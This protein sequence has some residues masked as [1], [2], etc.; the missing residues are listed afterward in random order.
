MNRIYKVIWNR[1]RHCYVVVSEIAKNHGKEH[2]TNLCVSKRL[3]ALTLAIGLSLSSYAFVM[4]ADSVNLGNNA[5]AA[6]D[7][8]GNLTIGNEKT[9]ADGANKNGKNNTTIGTDSDTLRNVTEG[10]TKKNGQ[11]MDTDAN[12]QL[13]EGEGKAHDLDTSTEAGGSTAMGYNTHNEGDNSTAIGNNAK[14]TNK[15]V[16]YYVDAD[17]KKTASADNAAWYK[18]ASGNPTKVPQVFRDAGGNKTTT[19]QYVHTYTEKDPTTGENVTK[20]E[21]TSDATKADKDSGGNPVYNYE[22]ADNTDKLY[23][24]TL[25]QA[26]SNSIAAG[27]NVTAKG[28]NAV[29]VG[30]NSSADNSAVAIGDT[31]KAKENAVAMGKDTK[32]MAEGSIAL[33]KDSEADRDGGVAGWDPKTGTASTKSDVAWKSGE[34]ALSIGNGGASR[35]ITNVAAGSEDSDAVNLAQLKNAMTHY[36]SV[37]T[38]SDTDAAG[39]NNYLNDGA[40]GDNALAAGVGA[41]ASSDDATA[42]GTDANAT[43]SQATA[44]GRSASASSYQDTAIGYNAGAHG[45]YATAVGSSASATSFQSTAIGYNAGAHGSYAIAMGNGAS[46]TN[47]YAMAIGASANASYENSTAVGASAKA[48]ATY[49]TALGNGASA[50]SY[51]STAVGNGASASSYE[52]TAIGSGAGADGSYAIAMGNGASATNSYAVAIGAGANAPSYQATALGNG[53]SATSS[54]A[55]A[56][57]TGAGAHG[58]SATALGNGASANSSYATALGSGATAQLS[59]DTAIGSSAKASGGDATALGYNAQATAPNATAL[60]SGASAY[61]HAIAIGAASASSSYA[62]AAGDGANAQEYQAIALGYNAKSNVTGGV[63][64]GS[65]STANVESGK[66]GLDPHTGAASTN[67]G[68]TWVSTLGAVSVGTVDSD[69]NA[70]GT[71]QINGLAA[72]TNDTDAVN[73]AQLKALETRINMH[74]YSVNSTLSGD[75][76]NYD[77]TGAS[78]TNALAA[79]PMA[80]ASGEDAVAIGYGAQAEGKGA[81]VIGQYGKATGRY[82]LAFG[83]QQTD[84]TAEQADNVASGD[85]ALSFG[86]RTTAS[87]TNSTAF[88]WQTTANAKRA[89]AFGERTTASGANA[90]VFGQLATASGQNSVAFGNEAVANNYGSTAFGNRTEALGE[91]STAFGNSTVAAGMNTAAFGTDNVA[92]AVLDDNG[93][94]TNIIY[95]TNNNGR[96]VKDTNGNPIELSREKMDARGN[97]AYL[98]GSGH[99]KSVTYTVPG[100]ETHSYVLLQGT[101][102]NTYIRDYRGHIRSATIGTDG[103]VTVGDTASADVTLK[104]ATAGANG[105]HILSNANATVW[106]ENSIASGEASTA[107]GVGSI[108]AAQNSLAA[109]GGTVGESATNAAAIGSGAKATLEDSVALGSGAVADR[110]SGAKGYD[111]LTKGDTTNT[112][113]AWVSN[114]NAIAVGNG[115]TLTRQ[116]TGVAAGS[117]DTDAVNVAQ[118][119]AAGFKVTTQNDGSISSSI[120][121][122]DTLDFEGKDNAI[123]ST[124]KDSK[125]ITVAVSKTPTFDSAT[126]Y[127]P[128]PSEGQNNEKVTISNGHI[129]TYNKNQQER[130]V[131]GTDNQGSGT[132]HLINNDLSQVHVYTQNSKDDGNDGITRMYYIS[133]SGNGGE[134][135]GVHTIAV[136]D[137]GI[138]YAGDNVKPNTSDKVVVKH[139]LNSTMDVTGGAD[140]NNL[141]EGNIGVVATPAVEDDQGNITQKAKLELKLNKDLT[142]LNTVTAGTAQIGSA[143]AD[144][145]KLTENGAVT[146]KTA[147][148][149]SYVTGLDNKDWSTTNPSYVSGRAATEDQLAAVSGTI[150]KGLSFT[151]NTQDATNT[152][153]NYTGYKVVNRK[154]GDTIAIKAGDADASRHYATTNLTTEIA[155]N[156]DITIKMD[157]SPTFTE[158]TASSFNLSP[159]DTTTKDKAGNTASAQLNAHY[160]DGSLNPDKNVT[161]ADGSTGMVRLHYH[162]GEGTIHDLA[163]MDDG[164][165]YAGDIK[166][167][168]S[169]DTTGFGRKMNEKTTI[170]GGVT[171]KDNLSD[172][173]IGVVSDGTSTL[174]VKLA[175]DLKNLN[176]V[177]TGKTIQNDSGITITNDIHNPNKTVAVK[178]DEVTFGGNQVTNM[179]SGADG[180]AD[181]K[182]DGTP[183]YNT[184][185]NGANIGDVK[186]IAGSTT[187]AAK[188]TGD[189]NITV[190]YNDSTA[191]GKNTVKLND[192]IT[193][194]S[195]ADK[196]VTIDGT[197]G[198]ITA[199]GK[200]SLDGSTG[201]GSIGGVTIGNQTGVTTT[202]MD[203][204]KAKTEDGTFVTGLSNKT[205][206][207]DSNGIVSGRAATED[208]LKTVSDTVNAGWELDVNGTKQKAVTPTSSKVNFVQGQNIS[209]SG[210]GDD[211]IVA[212]AD[213]VRFTTIHVTGDKDDSGSYIGG[214]TI[215]KQSGGNS[216]NPGPGYY[217]TGLENKSWNASQIQSGRAAT[218]DQLKQVAE[219]I[220]H[221]TVDGDKYVTGGTATY[222]DDGKGSAKL[223]GTNGLE[224]T[225]AN[226]H[227]YYVTKGEVSDDG[228]TLKMTKND[229]T[230]FD[231]N[232]GKIMQ[233][234][235]RL[236]QNPA[237]EDGKYTVDSDGNLKLTVQD[238]NGTEATRQTITLSGLASK[239][240]VDK[241]LTFAANSG[242]PYKA[243]LG[244]TVTVKGSAVKAGHDYSDENLTTEVDGNGNITIKMDKDLTADTMTV[245]GK[246]G[247]DGQIGITGKDGA[248]GTVTTIIKTIGK[249]GTNG[250]DGTPGVN[251]TDGITRIVYQDGKDG[252]A[253]MTTHTVATLD[254]GLKFGANAPVAGKT[255]N[256]VGNKMNSTINI[257]GAGTKELQDYSGKNLLTSVEQD[258]AGNTTIHVLMDRNISADGVTVG[259]AGKDG[260][261]GADSEVG[262][263][264]TIGINGKNGV[265][266]TDGKQGITTTIIR[267]EKGQAGKDGEIGQQG[268]PGVDGKDITRIVYQN[269]QDKVDGKDGSHTVA[270]LD[271]GLKFSGD[272]NKV[273]T[274]KLNEQLQFVGGADKNKLTE[275]NIGINELEDGKLT[276][277]L[278]N[279]P[280]LGENGNLTAGSAQIG[281]FAGDTLDMTKDGTNPSGNKAKAGSYA[282]G[283]SNKDWNVADP[284]YVS[285]R[286]ATEDQLAKVSEA[287]GNATTAA[288]KR[289]VVTVNDKSNPAEATPSATAGAYGDYDSTGGNLMIAAKK[290]SD[291]VLTY[292]IKLNDQLAIGQKGEPGVAGKDGKDGKVT[293]E[294]KGG[295]TVVIGHDGE[296][297]KDGKD[298]IFVTGKDG[299]DGV[300]ITGPDGAAGTDGKVGIAGTDGKDAVS[301]SGKDGVGHIGLIGPKGADGK[302]ADIDIS[303]VLGKATLDRSQN[304][305]QSD[306]KDGVKDQASRIQYQTIVKEADGTSRT[307]THEV[308]TM[309]D[310]LKI[311][312]NAA[313]KE[314]AANPVSNKLNSTINIKGSD[315]KAD[316]TYT[317]DNL[318]TTVE[319]DTDGNTTVKVLMD[320]D[321]TGNSVIVGE[322]GESGAPGKDGV[323]GTIGVNGKDGSGVVIKGKDGISI[324]GKDGLNGVTIKGVGGTD[325]TEGHIGLVGPKGPKGA[326]GKDGQNASADIHVVNGRVGV[327]GTDGNKGTNGM[328][329][330]VYED[331]NHITHEVATMD[332]GLKFIGDDSTA[333]PVTKKLNDTLQ[334]RGDGT[335]DEKTKTSNGNIQTSVADGT[336]KVALNDKINLH[337]DGSLT[338]GGDTQDGS[339]DSK[340]PI[341]IKHF[342]DK[343][344]DM[345]GV[346]KDGKPTTSKEGKAGDYVTGLDNKDWD[347]SSPTYVSGRAA[348]EDQLKKVSD[349]VNSAAA[350][351]GKHT[352][353]TV[354]DKDSNNETEAKAGT[355]TFGDYAGADKGNLLIAAKND[356]GQMTYNIKLNDQLAIGQK[357][358][359]GVA[360]KDGKDGKVTVE[361]KGGT[362]VV[363][364]HDGEPGKDGKDGL[365]VT[366]KDGADGVS[367]TGPQGAAGTDGIDGKVGIAGKDGNDAVS[368]SGKDGVGHIGLTGPKGEQGKDGISIDIT[369]DLK[370]PTLDSTKNVSTTVKEATSGQ[371]TTI[372]QAPR[373]QYESNGKNYEVATMDDGL[374][375]IGNDGKEVT[376]KLNSTLSITG[377]MDKD[378]VTTASSKNLGVRSNKDGDGLEIVMTD[379]PDFTKVTVGEGTDPNSKITIG[380]QTV[381]GKK[382]DGTAGTAETGKYITGLDNTKWNKDNVIENRAATEGQLRDIAG[383]ITNQNQGGGFALTSDEKGDDKIVKQDLGKA[384]QIKGDTT[385]KTDGSVEKADNIKTSIDNGAIKVELNKDVDL[386]KEGSIKA[387]ETTIHKDGVDTNKI[388]IKDSSIS[389]SKDGINGGNKQIT[390]VASGA[391][392]ITKGADGKDI[393]KYDNETNAANIGDVKRIAGDMKTEI[394]NNIS[395]VTNKVDQIGQH[396]DNIQKDVTQLKTDVKADRTYQGDDGAAKKVK[397]KFGSCLSLTGG[398]KLADLTEEGNIGVVQKEIEDPDH[399]GEKIAGLSVRLAKHLNLEKT[400]YTS[401]ENGQTYTSEIDGKGLTIKTGDENRNI[402]VQDG[403]VNMGGNQIHNVAPGQAPGDAVNVSQLNATNYAV[404]KLGTRVNRVGAGA[405]ALAALHPLDFDP[406]D[407]WDFAAGYGNYKD[408]SAVAV[409]AYYRPNEDTMFNIGGSF[410]GGENMVNAGVSFKVGQGNHVST[411]RVAMAKEIKDLRQNV[412]NLNAIVN[413]QSALID[414]LTGTNAGMIKDK[415]NDLF[416][417]VPANHWAYEYVTKLKQAGI[418][419]GY[420][421]GNFD[422]DRM[423][424]RYEFAAIVY[425][426]IMAGAA[427]NPALNQDGTL[428]KLAN[429]FSSEMKYIRIDTIAKD[430]NGKPTIERVRVIPDT[431]HDVQS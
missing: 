169:L 405:A 269:D 244:D 198:T 357:G 230:T 38:T 277:Q 200:V 92:G 404:N 4:A 220:K 106:G 6:Y 71:R 251:G 341:I 34:G 162:D 139:K 237:R 156:G 104:Q 197:A 172:N 374:K 271:D 355:G 209:I 247:K 94:Y 190:T 207:P 295:T 270:T 204:D 240:E 377:G 298:G 75:G 392:E 206:N 187:D 50:S 328:D 323:D 47:T 22:K 306:D 254:D 345:T 358:E 154:L 337:Q 211:V 23:S 60:G 385:Y 380:K 188:L 36:Y 224:G 10:E 119:K 339:T 134:I 215:G 371:E 287:I 191:D 391:T 381:T 363:I 3:V 214:I 430:K 239:A 331:H 82:A 429:E 54:Q 44:I 389:I 406:D 379:T 168:G 273:I 166:T 151:T 332:D 20:T 359:P 312:A 418:L 396:V 129:S 402:T 43:A 5:T 361:T 137:D 125:T 407:K 62:L 302:N 177:T 424:T 246:D 315:A 367:I 264:G 259:Q 69:G 419:T 199:G 160:R 253:G 99:T 124:S 364:G 201:T 107:F 192:S 326:D 234:D 353:V 143:P 327:D 86:E 289:T 431:Q 403:N 313:A 153:D 386:T 398:A 46:A 178:G 354:N 278:V 281:W 181:G 368:I 297:G 35:Q 112:S 176:S 275:N 279:T 412:A 241:G 305:V 400:T 147:P 58:T 157:E 52:S 184:L 408:A 388:T 135:Q 189:S 318:T 122:G 343:T 100:G 33:G 362:T 28:S 18:N 349:A 272:D 45:T 350:T 410:G 195:D 415:G 300:S 233:S 333:T 301:I 53:A 228:K 79:G 304:E 170:N 165:V 347:V 324:N 76:S 161:M 284:E 83:G 325:G 167:D 65:S 232:L 238:A 366:G 179:G 149:G 118:L 334:I 175:K 299:A 411:S 115:S 42:V 427:S 255:V 261:A 422:G 123:V 59:D 87:G 252:D 321:I 309:D 249:N 63:A 276:I 136:L 282:T 80:R 311:G 148:A 110:K 1:V 70:T 393:Y 420:P 342:D 369:T 155:N 12:S 111:M 93:A 346:D 213:D 127:N 78:G 194:G 292:N 372:E 48:T 322:K 414:K 103:T 416:P 227:D 242:T 81:T 32:A 25:Y 394:N 217:I 102:G 11:P 16:T 222:G 245:S 219:D 303:T 375:F 266:G 183:T 223:T 409:G 51:E 19:P 382:S 373:I 98:D 344:L 338:V 101:D 258:A 226:L 113:T 250:K 395:N 285:G 182:P 150:N 67:T 231:V 56:I 95:K 257:K 280:N 283:L 205:W 378:A 126:F 267:T 268:A 428:D 90:T 335:Y 225:I 397:V 74:Y 37:K 336:I 8:K 329:R 117:Q 9:V 72:G 319:Q 130:A 308:A 146:E 96:V 105:Y 383:S 15:P 218:E 173:N 274:K 128:N 376:R 296:P 30:Y 77:N 203:G 114:A 356:N 360:G 260:V 262:Q 142:G 174:T 171:N 317:D 55:T 202:K 185:T 229:G 384:I 41:T 17:G 286:A 66:T 288:G 145:L 39:N 196:K 61:Y 186:N 248:D 40:T 291:G 68:T 417:D 216:A 208:Q 320:K 158:V 307:I 387:G 138:N 423:M 31:A 330:V 133:S 243:K 13:V 351:A 340:D 121:N 163:T 7:T 2:S 108:A 365:F 73:V 236:V 26:A 88:G 210:S 314:N 426:A 27:T 85:N 348:T 29:A 193:L 49:A 140:T 310:G 64:L 390:N 256:P 265:A 290:D 235:M 425:R 399:K 91:Y 57:G 212:T 294:T 293:V 21:I 116:I 144:T 97:L 180:T 413:R 131:L 352:V 316:H 221:G 141:S 132:L 401:N 421:D 24:V 89:T 152:T 14:I 370:A 84:T 159:K 263:A 164:Q 120:L 109:L